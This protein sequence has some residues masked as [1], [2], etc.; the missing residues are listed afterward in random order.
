MVA[1]SGMACHTIS[2]RQTYG[3]LA[4]AINWKR[5]CSTPTRNGAFCVSC[6]C[7]LYKWH[8][9]TIIT[10]LASAAACF[11][12]RRTAFHGL[13]DCFYASANNI[14]RKA[15]CFCVV[16]PA[17]RTSVNTY[18][19]W[20]A[21]SAVTGRISMKLG[22]N[23]HPPSKLGWKDFQGQRSNVKVIARP[24]AFFRQRDSDQ[25]TAD[26][27]LC[28]RRI[29]TDRTCTDLFRSSVFVLIFTTLLLILT[30][31]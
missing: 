10:V 19:T 31:S 16:C 18:F 3:W 4:S 7:K 17:G 2:S 9:I 1:F 5:F 25:L 22:T 30:P 15:L 29:Y 26:C 20:R 14:R 11:P 23:I 8:D 13:Y 27:L 24:N 6:E 28:V 21:L 12:T